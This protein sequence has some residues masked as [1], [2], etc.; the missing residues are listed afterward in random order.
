MGDVTLK[1][2][3]LMELIKMCMNERKRYWQ[4][5]IRA[6][7]QTLEAYNTQK[8][9]E[10]VV[11]GE[12]LSRLQIDFDQSE[13]CQPDNDPPDVV[14]RGYNFEILFVTG[15]RRPHQESKNELLNVIKEN[16]NGRDIRMVPYKSPNK[17]S[18]SEI[19]DIV[20]ISLSKKSERYAI[21]FKNDLNMLVY[22]MQ[23]NIPNL[24]STFPGIKNLI[25]QG[26][27]SVSLMISN[28]IIVLHGNSKAPS[29]IKNI[30]QKPISSQFLQW[31]IPNQWK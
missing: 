28:F 5:L 24:K 10:L 16:A 13:I 30:I 19:I 17:L 23:N 25:D 4:D 9:G 18:L 14:F 7:E 27:L 6:H 29:Y 12:F 3:Q 8:L 31:W 26:W 20:E 11:F 22:I 21:Q 2:C 1:V 15:E